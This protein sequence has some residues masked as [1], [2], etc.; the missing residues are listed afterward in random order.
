MWLL[1]KLGI[2]RARSA[3]K[4]RCRR[5]LWLQGVAELQR[6]TL[7]GSRES[8]A[9]LL[10]RQLE[11]VRQIERFAFYDDLD[12]NALDT[13]IVTFHGV[14]YPKL[15]DVCQAENLTVIADVHVHPG[16]YSQSPSDKSQPAMPRAGHIA[17][18]IP[19]YARR[20]VEPGGIGQY[21]YL[22][23][24]RW[25]NQTTAGKRFFSLD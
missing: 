3:P 18:I 7:G 20:R 23:E 12:P 25:K 24:Q 6:R 10:G 11:S 2:G 15:W 22:G 14:H 16:S 1:N 17:L 9:F 8:G 5:D 4:L 21:E 13:G 19:D